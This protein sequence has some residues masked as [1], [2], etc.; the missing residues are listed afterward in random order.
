M[1]LFS[2][3]GLFGRSV[4]TCRSLLRVCFDMAIS[5]VGLFLHAGLFCV[6]VLTCWS[7]LW[8]CFDM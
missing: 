4:L 8:V 1:F 5:F 2:D 7:L 6:S 3:V